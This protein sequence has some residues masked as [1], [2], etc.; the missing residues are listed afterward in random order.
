MTTLTPPGTDRSARALA[1]AA[2]AVSLAG[3]LLLAMRQSFT[4]RMTGGLTPAQAIIGVCTLVLAVLWWRGT[5]SLRPPLAAVIA[6]VY[7][8]AAMLSYDGAA[9]RGMTAAAQALADR[10][11][12]NAVLATLAFLV[13]PVVVTT[14]RQVVWVLR[15]L[16]IGGALS[17]T[18]GIIQSTIGID[19]AS[20]VKLPGLKDDSAVLVTSLMRAGSVRAQGSAGHP[21]ELG[22][23]LTVLIPI[24]LALAFEARTRAKS[25]RPWAGLTLLLVAG[26]LMTGSRSVMLGLSVALLV[27]GVYWPLRRTLWVVGTIVVA[28]GLSLLARLPIVA[29]L[30]NT[31]INGSGDSSLQS[32][33][34]GTQYVAEHFATHLWLGQGFGTYDVTVQPVLDNNYLTILMEQGLTGLVAAAM[35]FSL[36]CVIAQFVAR[37]RIRRRDPGLADLGVGLA[38]GLAA[39]I[40]IGF[41]LDIGAFQQISMLMAIL[42]PLAICLLRLSRQATDPGAGN[43]GHRVTVAV[44]QRDNHIVVPEGLGPR[45]DAAV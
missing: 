24:S 34:N 45:G 33:T 12:I 19:V 36:G 6:L 13:I 8:L 7:L 25:W 31:L 30:T 3:L 39:V 35:Y 28:V 20:F 14:R 32:R 44:R 43:H 4:V 41:V 26:A 5:I 9:I 2:H 23:V 22:A 11:L 27:A 16:V 21:L 29:N 38:G 1:W 40:V 10:A 17:A 18:F 15:L 42:T 37:R